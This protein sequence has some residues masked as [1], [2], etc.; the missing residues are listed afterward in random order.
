MNYERW[1]EMLAV[2]FDMTSS[3][4][5]SI[6]CL[7]SLFVKNGIYAPQLQKEIESY[8]AD[9]DATSQMSV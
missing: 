6:F 8:L 4:E 1:A 2:F 5:K 3:F 9:K 7:L